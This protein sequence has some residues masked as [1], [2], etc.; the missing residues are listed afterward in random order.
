MKLQPNFSW[1][2]YLDNEEDS[3]DQFQFQLQSQHKLVANAINATIDDISYW[4]IEKPTGETWID[5]NQIF[6]KTLT[7]IIVGSIATP[8]PIGST[9]LNLVSMTGIMQDTVPMTSMGMPLPFINSSNQNVGIYTSP[10][11]V[12]VD[13]FDGTWTGYTFYITLKYTKQR[14]NNGST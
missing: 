3:K 4:T 5:Q 2:K 7:G 12:T 1:Q 13:A 9:M 11:T 14:G 8:Y 10:T 6:T